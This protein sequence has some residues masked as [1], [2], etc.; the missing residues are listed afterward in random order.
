MCH[1]HHSPYR[2]VQNPFKGL[3]HPVLI[4]ENTTGSD[5]SMFIGCTTHH[6]KSYSTIQAHL[7]IQALTWPFLSTS[8][9][10]APVGLLLRAM[11]WLLFVRV[12][13]LTILSLQ[14]SLFAE[15]PIGIVSCS[16]VD[17]FILLLSWP[18]GGKFNV[19]LHIQ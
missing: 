1:V 4:P 17:A 19:L 12:S 13:Y 14:L 5:V 3:Q 10:E 11:Q 2:A 16:H 6:V 9:I 8:P 18:I 7:L 15:E